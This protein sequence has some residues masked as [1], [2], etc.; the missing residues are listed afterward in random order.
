ELGDLWVL[1]LAS[2]CEGSTTTAWREVQIPSG[3]HCPTLCAASGILLS[4]FLVLFGGHNYDSGRVN[5]FGDGCP[6]HSYKMNKSCVVDL[7]KVA[8]LGDEKLTPTV[9]QLILTFHDG[10]PSSTLQ[11][12]SLCPRDLT[13]RSIKGAAVHST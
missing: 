4:H 11:L 3:L 8:A 9:L 13:P 7:A 10:I 5:H 1:D 6:V 12:P 2:Y